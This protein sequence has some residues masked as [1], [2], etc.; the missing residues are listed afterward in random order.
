MDE[1]EK[2]KKELD[3]TRKQMRD[4][5]KDLAP[6]NI[7]AIAKEHADTMRENRQIKAQLGNAFKLRDENIEMRAELL[8][9]RY[10]LK[11]WRRVAAEQQIEP[12]LLADT[13][14]LLA[15]TLVLDEGG[16]AVE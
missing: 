4:L 9:T 3:A 10:V 12:D 1:L 16:D 6:Q 8:R 11:Q 7:A 5:E 2:V 15:S 13:E 14:E